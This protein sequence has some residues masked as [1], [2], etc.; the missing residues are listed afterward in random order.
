MVRLTN[1]MMKKKPAKE[2]RADEFME[3]TPSIP[4]WK[5][6]HPKLVVPNPPEEEKAKVRR[7]VEL[8]DASTKEEFAQVEKIILDKCDSGHLEASEAH[9]ALVK[10]RLKVFG[11]CGA[12]KITPAGDLE[13]ETPPPPPM[14]PWWESP[15]ERPA[16]PQ[17]EID[18]EAEELDPEEGGP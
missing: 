10:L 4:S 15:D 2:S 6:T 9:R 8:L 3:N 1:P 7:D 12:G 18:D 11:G 17:W 14:E 13:L 5:E 16:K